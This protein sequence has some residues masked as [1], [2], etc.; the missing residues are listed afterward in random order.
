MEKLK[1]CPFCG[2]EPT[3]RLKPWHGAP[4]RTRICCL[5]LEC[6]AMPAV[7][8]KTHSQAVER[9]NQRAKEAK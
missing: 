6:K 7:M 3:T 8:G 4:E 5:N 9:W 2:G 1:P